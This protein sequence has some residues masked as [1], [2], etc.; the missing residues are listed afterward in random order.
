MIKETITQK[1]VN[2]TIRTRYCDDCGDKIMKES[3]T[4]VH[5][6]YCKKDICKKCVGHEDSGSG[7]YNN[8]FCKACWELGN[9]YRIKIAQFENEIEKLQDEW[10]SKCK[11]NKK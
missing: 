2:E 1:T 4:S 10:Q 9:E 11:N 8:I 3:Y 7:D 5:C 6:E